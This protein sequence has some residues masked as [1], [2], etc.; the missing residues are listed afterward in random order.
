VNKKDLKKDPFF[1]GFDW[2]K[3][4]RKEIP[5]PKLDPIDDDDIDMPMVK[6]LKIA[7]FDLNLIEP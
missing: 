4:Q 1:K 3:L 2:D 7:Y 5:A 6:T